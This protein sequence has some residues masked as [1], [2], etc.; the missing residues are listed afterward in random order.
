MPNISYQTFAKPKNVYWV[1]PQFP[2]LQALRQN[3]LLKTQVDKRLKELSDT[4]NSGMKLK[5]LH[6]GLVE[7]MVQRKIKWPHEYVLSSVAKERISYDNVS[8]TQWVAG[9]CRIM[10]E[11]KI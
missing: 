5:S 6:G 10:K 2:D 11:D 4:E 1:K 3:A 7:V 9:I 8:I